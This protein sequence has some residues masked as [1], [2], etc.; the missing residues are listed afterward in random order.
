MGGVRGI[1][2]EEDV[3]SGKVEII[4]PRDFMQYAISENIYAGNAMT[5]RMFFQ[6]GVLLPASP[7][8]HAGQGLSQNVAAALVKH[9]PGHGVASV[10]IL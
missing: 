3:R 6:Y 2:D 1:V 5:R 10:N 8:G 7:Y 4:A 9:S